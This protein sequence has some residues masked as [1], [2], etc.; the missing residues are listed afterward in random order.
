MGQVN[1]GGVIAAG[2]VFNSSLTPFSSL[3]KMPMQQRN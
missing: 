1:V 2:L 3:W